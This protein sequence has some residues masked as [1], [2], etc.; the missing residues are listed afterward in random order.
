VTHLEI[1]LESSHRGKAGNDTATRHGARR[2]LVA[3][4]DDVNFPHDFSLPPRITVHHRDAS[5]IRIQP[6]EISFIIRARTQSRRPAG[7]ADD[8][9]SARRARRAASRLKFPTANNARAQS[10]PAIIVHAFRCLPRLSSSSSSMPRHN[11][12][13]IR[14][15]NASLTEATSRRDIR[16]ARAA[17]TDRARSPNF[18]R[19]FSEVHAHSGLT[20]R[21]K[22]RSWLH[23]SSIRFHSFRDDKY[24]SRARD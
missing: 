18:H 5:F 14:D 13:A 21:W 22:R 2:E 23:H 24:A 6:A 10:D 3:G 8:R 7:F 11:D 9:D 15:A 4:P 1:G 19:A 16:L 17:F 20:F 12:N